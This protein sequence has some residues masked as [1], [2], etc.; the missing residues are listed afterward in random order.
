MKISVIGTGYVG[1]VTGVCF[2][3]L[4][5]EVSCIDIDKEKIEKLK[6]GISPIYE[7]GIEKLLKKN[8]NNGRLKFFNNTKEGIT[9]AEVIFIAVG[10]PPKDDGTVETKYV[11]S[12]AETIGRALDHFAVI[13]NKSTVPIGTGE[14]VKGIISKHCKQKFDVVS[15]PEFLREGQALNDF[16]KPD[17]VVI[18]VE[19]VKAHGIMARLY[20]PVKTEVM[21]TNLRTAEMIKY[22]SNAYMATSISFINSLAE[23]C[24]KIGADVRDVAQG[25]KLDKRVGKYAFLNAGPGYGGSCFPKDVKGLLSIARQKEVDLPLLRVAEDINKH[26]GVIVYEKVLNLIKRLKGKKIAVWGLAFKPETDD[27]RESPAVELISKLLAGSAEV[28][29]FDSVAE[30]NGKK[31]FPTVNFAKDPIKMLDGVDCLVIMTDWKKFKEISLKEINKLI[32]VAN[33]V[34]T[35]NIYNK[36]EAVGLGFNYEGIGQ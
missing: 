18:G 28:S 25:M 5:D 21:F 13:V 20:R 31:M 7:P 19:S 15:N 17:R 12:A 27:L 32:G 11:E 36:E 33:L 34:D 14:R 29:C 22:A 30:K 10:T 2:A 35:R 8:I 3:E 6:K 26:Q 9:K 23:L 16:M 4:G 1:L 24:E